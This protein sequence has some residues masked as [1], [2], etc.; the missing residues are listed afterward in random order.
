MP[1]MS[2]QR[3]NIVLITVDQLRH[4]WVGYRGA[5]W[6]RTPHIDALAERGVAFTNCCATA[7]L[8]APARISL[9]TGLS[10]IRFAHVN[11]NAYLPLSRPTY[12]QRL[13]DAGYHVA[14]TGKLDLAK[15]DEYNGIRGDRPIAFSWGFTHPLECEGKMHAG[16]VR[17]SDGA[18]QGPYGHY[19][20]GRG[21]FEAF[22]DDY[23][24]RRANGECERAAWDSVLDPE[25]FED[26]FIGRRAVEWIRSRDD[27]FPWHLF[28]SFVGPH[29]PFDPPTEY[30]EHFR[31]RE[32]PE[33]IPADPTGKPPHIGRRMN[34]DLDPE[35]VLVARR[36][37]A[38]AIEAIDDQVGAIVAA[39]EER[40]ELESTYIV[41]SSDHGE[42]LGDHGCWTKRLHYEPALR[43]PL[44][45]VGPDIAPGVR[46]QLVEWHDIHP[47]LCEI[48]GVAIPGAL[49][50]DAI[51]AK[52]LCATLQDATVPHRED[53]FSVLH[54]A[55]CLRTATHKLIDGRT[56]FVELYDLSADPDERNNIA[57]ERPDLV[58]ALGGR[59]KERY[60]EGGANR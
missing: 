49:H 56:G 24:R 2:E 46:E 3:P 19:L 50:P 44:V 36:Q 16:R 39:L 9:A 7:P 13:R 43:V 53:C 34:V 1:A 28:V 12:Y 41:F 45:V 55:L 6:V 4:D 37:Y 40:G 30:A 58:G 59:L 31:T 11:N 17:A 14:V 47:T 15:P 5:D 23:A 10:P 33:P 22:I 42:M 60:L 32:M 18:P 54:D 21:V 48:A 8:C 27:E 57:S 20:K 29:N 26:A 51:D 52:S 25:D 35:K 38:A